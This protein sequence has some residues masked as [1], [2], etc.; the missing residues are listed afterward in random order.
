MPGRGSR[1]RRVPSPA[2]PAPGWE[3]AFGDYLY[4]SFTN[5][6]AFS[7]T[8]VLPLSRWAKTAMTVQAVVSIV[9]VALVVARA[10]NILQ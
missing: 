4:L 10:V 8:D 3:P 5:A 9:T 7:P 2:A 6:A 1:R